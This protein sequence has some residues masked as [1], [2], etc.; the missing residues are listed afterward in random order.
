M[1]KILKLKDKE[2]V[3]KFSILVKEEKEATAQV[4]EKEAIASVVSHLAEIDRRKLYA[5]EG[6]SSLFNYVTQKYHYS[7]GAAYRRIQAAR[8]SLRFPE[9]MELL[10]EGKINL[11]NLSLVAPHL[12]QNNKEKIF[13]AIFHKSTREV[14]SIISSY[15]GKRKEVKDKIR[16]LPPLAPKIAQNFT[17]SAESNERREPEIRK[18]PEGSLAIPLVLS[19]H[20]MQVKEQR[21]VKIEFE[22]S[23]VL[24]Q[25]IQRA[26]EILRHRYPQGKLED[27]LN[28]ALE[29]LLEKKDPE[30]K[31]QR[32]LEKKSS[33][34]KSETRYIPQTIQREVYQRDE[35]QCSYV[36]PEGKH[37][38]EKNFLELD[39]IHP[40]SLGGDSTPENLR[41]LCRTHNQWRAEKTFSH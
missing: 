33:D 38:A 4:E 41:L 8:L 34:V 19:D 18:E 17:F 28:E 25:K 26:R 32:T 16:V 5:L 27:I 23:E 12:N 24:A 30:R 13:S 9:I 10:K 35:G 7:E 1:N 6:Y 14:E 37:C 15:V 39:H 22:A 20:D 29:L 36:S 21:R 40:W 31:I 11:M 2:L 3:E